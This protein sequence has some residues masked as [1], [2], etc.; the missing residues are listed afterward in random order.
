MKNRTPALIREQKSS[1]ERFLTGDQMLEFAKSHPSL[2]PA[3]I[4][5]YFAEEHPDQTERGYDAIFRTVKAFPPSHRHPAVGFTKHQ[6]LAEVSKRNLYRDYNL[7][8]TS[9]QWSKAL[10]DALNLIHD[11]DITV[12]E[13]TEKGGAKRLLRDCLQKVIGA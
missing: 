9:E 4:C 5:R 12:N 13:L 11:Q 7:N 1:V 2:R 6:A 8:P 10:R 3:D